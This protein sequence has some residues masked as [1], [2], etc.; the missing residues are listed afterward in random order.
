MRAPSPGDCPGSRGMVPRLASGEVGAIPSGLKAGTHRPRAW[1]G[2]HEQLLLL[3]PIKEVSPGGEGTRR[4]RGITQQMS[5]LGFCPEEGMGGV[6]WTFAVGR[7]WVAG[8]TGAQ[9]PAPLPGDASHREWGPSKWACLCSEAPSD[10]WDGVRC[11]PHAPGRPQPEPP[12]LHS[13]PCPPVGL[14]LPDFGNH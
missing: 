8:G 12:S 4:Q 11:Q 7:V 13:P 2:F 3:A 5:L 1:A 10:L 14:G 9:R 6:K